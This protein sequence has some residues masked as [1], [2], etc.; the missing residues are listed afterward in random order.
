[1]NENGILSPSRK[2]E[3]LSPQFETR[4]FPSRKSLPYMK[5]GLL[6]AE[7]RILKAELNNVKAENHQQPTPLSQNDWILYQVQALKNL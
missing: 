6:L 4:V 3:L 2:L 7:R 5:T 1:M